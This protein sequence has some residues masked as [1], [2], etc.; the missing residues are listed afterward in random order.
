MLIKIIGL[1]L[2]LGLVTFFLLKSAPVVQNG[3]SAQVYSAPAVQVQNE[4]EPPLKLKSIG[5]EFS[6]FKFTKEKLQVGRL[7][8]GYGFYI[9]KGNDNPAKYNPQPTFIVPLGTPVRSIVDGIVAAMPTVWSGD[10]SIQVTA[11]GKMQKWVYETEHVINPKVKV[12]DRVTAG[13]II[14]EVSDFDKGA[15]AGFGTVEIGILKGGNPP[16][17]IC[18]FAY[19]DDSIKEET[20][21]KLKNLFRDW[22]EYTGNT[23]LYDELLTVPGCLIP[24]PIKG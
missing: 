10:Y 19:L 12:G 8:M 6:D 2:I 22:E 18:P 13:Q 7:F 4:N 24:D 3:P 17:H 15:P 5:V 23:S 1:T 20:F 9:P 11:D 21:I 14:A 16:Q